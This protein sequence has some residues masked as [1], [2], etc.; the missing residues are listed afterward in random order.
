MSYGEKLSYKLIFCNG[1]CGTYK[2]VAYPSCKT[3]PRPYFKEE[4]K[5]ALPDKE[6]YIEMY[7][8]IIFTLL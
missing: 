7:L 2:K 1:N 3:N 4:N 5:A 6:L 8:N